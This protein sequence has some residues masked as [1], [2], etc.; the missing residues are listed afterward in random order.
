MCIRDSGCRDQVA[1]NSTWSTAVSIGQFVAIAVPFRSTTSRPGKTCPPSIAVCFDCLPN[2]LPGDERRKTGW[3][4]A[5]AAGDAGPWR[6]R[7][8]LGRG[9]W[10]A[11]AVDGVCA[12]EQALRCA[13]K[14]YVLGV[15]GDHRFGSGATSRLWPA[16]PRRLRANSILAQ[17]APVS[18]QRHQGRALSQLRL[19]RTRRSFG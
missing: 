16:P 15:K 14:G 7:A 18:G 5:G 8:I 13:G 9:R 12:I 11:D 19:F 3:M 10:D 1:Q 6:Q 17:A 2:G 4:R